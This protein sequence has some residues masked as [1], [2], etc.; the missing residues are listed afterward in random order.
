MTGGT[1]TEEPAGGGDTRRV[2]A[3]FGEIAAIPH[4]SGNEEALGEY[5]MR[6]GEEHGCSVSKDGANNIFLEKPGSPGSEDAP[7]VVLQAHM[8]MVCVKASGEEHN[9]AREGIDWYEEDG[10]IRARGTSLGADNGI[11]LAMGLALLADPGLTH[12]PLQL[13]ATTEEETTMHGAESLDPALIAGRTI[14]NLDDEKEGA[15]TVSSAGMFEARISVPAPRIRVAGEVSWHTVEVAGGRGGHSGIE[16]HTGRANALAL[17][18]GILAELMQEP[19]CAVASV[20]GGDRSNVIPGH[21]VA[22]I[23]LDGAARGAASRLIREEE[24]LVRGEY[25]VADPDLRI[26]IF[27]ASPQESVIAPDAAATVVHLLT[28]LPSG[29]LAMDPVV[30]GLVATSANPATCSMGTGIVHLTISAR[31]NDD[32]DLA[33]VADRLRTMGHEAGVPVEVLGVSPAWQRRETSP[34]REL[35]V[36]AYRDLFGTDPE[37]RALHAGLEAAQFARKIEDADI[38][39]TG[40][41]IYDAHTPRE[42]VTI[43]SIGR[44]YRLCATVLTRLAADGRKD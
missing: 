41:D 12:P 23:G 16:I 19:G 38:C 34:L 31:S 28:S 5:L 36:A 37:V 26:R 11:G 35:M 39:A 4:C 33:A 2:V 40:P 32:G 14:I 7:P 29:V 44:V 17:L 27:P 9:F 22:V 42:S 20:A 43:V 15:F 13:I 30:P 1:V 25:R 6:W 8:D 24:R 21:A 10:S 18:G 3:L